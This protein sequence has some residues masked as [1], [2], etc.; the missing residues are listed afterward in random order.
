MWF[1]V[2]GRAAGSSPGSMCLCRCGTFRTHRPAEY[3]GGA[4]Q[5]SL[6]CSIRRGRLYVAFKWDSPEKAFPRL[7]GNGVLKAWN[8]VKHIIV[9]NAL[10]TAE[11][12]MFPYTMWD[13]K[14]IEKKNAEHTLHKP[15]YF[16]NKCVLVCVSWVKNHCH[17]LWVKQIIIKETSLKGLLDITGKNMQC[18]VAKRL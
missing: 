4:F 5:S 12:L 3:F 14:I 6:P 17:S 2:P 11:R 13:N 9:R 15:P 7:T 10:M 16:L 1:S 18:F 8:R